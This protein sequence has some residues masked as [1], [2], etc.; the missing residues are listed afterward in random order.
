MKSF[1]WD[2]QELEELLIQ[3]KKLLEMKPSRKKREGIEEDIEFLE[4][5]L[6]LPQSLIENYSEELI[7][8]EEAKPPRQESLAHA[9]YQNYV[10]PY[11]NLTDKSFEHIAREAIHSVP[12]VE[13]YSPSEFKKTI[14]SDQE[15]VANVL[16]VLRKVNKEFAR[17][18]EDTLYGPNRI[19]ELLPISDEDYE[20]I[21]ELGTCYLDTFL[22]HPFAVI[23][24][25]Q[26]VLEFNTLGHELG[27]LYK[28]QFLSTQKEE[29]S[30]FLELEGYFIELI[31]NDF[32]QNYGYSQEESL[33]EV[34]NRIHI[35]N[36]FIQNLNIQYY[37]SK[38]AKYSPYYLS[39]HKLEKELEKQNI[40]IFINKCNAIGYIDSD[41]DENI[42]MIH[43]LL[44]ALDLYNLY[45]QDPEK[46]FYLLKRSFT[47]PTQSLE[48][49]LEKINATYHQDGYTN[50]KK[51]VKRLE[52]IKRES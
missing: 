12:E 52:P 51:F 22:P 35:I 41:F 33:K 29:N 3:K 26:T 46:A 9:L 16:E 43:S 49:Y 37:A 13:A 17:F 1:T 24:R 20:M 32:A 30:Y 2:K 45:R 7:V 6:Q 10:K 19:V 14:K 40:P 47:L 39:I 4:E 15:L 27:H 8:G 31:M 5:M 28:E 38:F 42:M 36:T 23:Y 48:E 50:L 44:G 18:A 34:Q 11:Q 25:N 21:P